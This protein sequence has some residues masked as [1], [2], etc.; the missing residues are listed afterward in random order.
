MSVLLTGCGRSG[1]P[2]P[3]N[4]AEAGSAPVTAAASEVATTANGAPK[5]AAG[6]WEL[7]NIG[8][9]GTVIGTQFLC[10]DAT[11]E[12][13]ASVFDQIA[14]NVNC[15]KYETARAGAGWTFDFTCGPAGMTAKTAGEVSGDFATTYQVKLTESDGTTEMSRTIEAK[16]VGDCPI[17]MTPGTLA[18]ERGEK[19]ADITN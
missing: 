16:R 18:D 19:I 13:K 1:G 7:K 2:A 12:D 4:E 15:E 3:A 5:R 11:S 10:V 6:H 14:K 17:G 9:G 8:G